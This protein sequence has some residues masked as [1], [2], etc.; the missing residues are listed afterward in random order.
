MANIGSSI[1]FG[2]AYLAYNVNAP[3]EEDAVVLFE[4]ITEVLIRF[5]DEQALRSEK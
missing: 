4:R 3:V 5:R 2:R 1:P